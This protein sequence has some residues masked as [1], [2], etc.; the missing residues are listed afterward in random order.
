MNSNGLNQHSISVI[1]SNGRMN[2]YAT[3]YLSAD[4]PFR[5]N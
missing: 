4:L 2:G 1:L 3:I 5:M